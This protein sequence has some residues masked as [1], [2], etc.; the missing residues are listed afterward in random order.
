MTMLMLWQ[1]VV[2]VMSVVEVVCCNAAMCNFMWPGMM[3]LQ[4]SENRFSGA[5]DRLTHEN[6]LD[7]CYIRLKLI[8][9]ILVG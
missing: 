1:V 7:V 6:T 4:C 5:T 2:F 9:A 8:I 3:F